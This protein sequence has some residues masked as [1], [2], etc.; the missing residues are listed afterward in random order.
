LVA[1]FAVLF[2]GAADFLLSA[3]FVHA[4]FFPPQAIGFT[5]YVL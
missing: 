3:F 2:L 5:S 1:F 4:V